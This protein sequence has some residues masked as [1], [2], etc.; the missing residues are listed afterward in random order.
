[1]ALHSK[2][3]PLELFHAKQVVNDFCF[4]R[5]TFQNFDIS[6]IDE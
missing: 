4:Y 6:G 2:T 1:M 3:V 5:E